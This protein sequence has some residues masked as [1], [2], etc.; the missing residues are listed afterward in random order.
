MYMSDA[1]TSNEEPLSTTLRRSARLDDDGAEQRPKQRSRSL[2]SYNQANAKALI[3]RM[4]H[5]FEYKVNQHRGCNSYKG[6][7]RS[8]FIQAPFAT[9]EDLL[10]KLPES[11]GFDVEISGSLPL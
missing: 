8:E 3:D 11:I 2:D 6:N 5:T 4:K 9:L 1:Q 7:V 10:T